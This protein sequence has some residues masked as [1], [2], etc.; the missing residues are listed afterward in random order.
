MT[1]LAPLLLLLQ[2]SALAGQSRSAHTD[3]TSYIHTFGKPL[4]VYDTYTFASPE[5]GKSRLKVFIAFVNDLLQFVKV[6]DHDYRARYE[7]VVEVLDAEGSHR[8]GSIRKD[9]LVARGYEETNSREIVSQQQFNFDLEPGS[10]ELLV[11][12][13]DLDTKRHLT[14][15]EKVELRDLRSAQ[16]SLS[17]LMFLDSIDPDS[18]EI[19]NA[20]PNMARTYESASSVAAVYFE[21]Y[22]TIVDSV[23]LNISIFDDDN[24]R[25]YN[26]ERTFFPDVEK[27]Q[28]LIPMSGLVP[29]AGQFYLVVEARAG[30]DKATSREGFIVQYAEQPF[31]HADFEN[32][33]AILNSLKYICDSK[34]Y[35]AILSA[36]GD[37]R[38]RLIDEFWLQRDPTPETPENELREE[39]YRRVDFTIRYF[40]V[41]AADRPGWQTDRGKIYIVYGPPSEVRRR[42]VDI[43]SNPYEFWYYDQIDRRFVFLDK[44][45]LGAYRLV[46]KD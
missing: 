8:A 22:T 45:G 2:A 30:T 29:A 37:P 33:T 7:I 1:N 24:E 11:E 12:L 19:T 43:D 40:S 26:Q 39:F 42:S 36:S 44:S 31:L 13:T 5:V 23:R 21:L 17:D 4:F 18:R 38:S 35:R 14:R 15:K 27:Y 41:T 20:V 10:Y 46:H 3:S 25:V 28:R 16:I 34:E 9:D 6:S 32:S